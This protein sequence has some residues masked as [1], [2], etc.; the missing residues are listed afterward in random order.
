MEAQGLGKKGLLQ[1]KVPRMSKF[2]FIGDHGVG[3]REAT[4]LVTV[5]SW[6]W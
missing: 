6:C 3:D 5:K 1:E 4:V 2:H